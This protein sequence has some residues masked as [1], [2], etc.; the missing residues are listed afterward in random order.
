[1]SELETT[2]VLITW[3]VDDYRLGLLKYTV[4]SLRRQTT[5]P[6]RLIVVDNGGSAQTD[7]LRTIGADIHVINR[8]NLGPGESRNMGARLALTPYLVFADND[9]EFCPRWLEMSLEVLRKHPGNIVRPGRTRQW[10][11]HAVQLGVLSDGVE[12]FTLAGSWLWVLE[13]AAFSEIGPFVTSDIDPIEDRDW[14]IRANRMGLHFLWPPAGTCIHRGRYKSFSK[15][16]RLR[17]GIWV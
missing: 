5:V 6:Y 4:E 3:S 15:K 10:K 2:I 8:V 17:N 7:Y 9:I 14:C 16:K 12:A 13:R 11:D 1:M